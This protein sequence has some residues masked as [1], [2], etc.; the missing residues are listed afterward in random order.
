MRIIVDYREKK[1]CE[2]LKAAVSNV[3]SALLP[4]G[5][6][7]LLNDDYAVVLERKTASDLVSSI[8][9]NRL[10]E[11]L[12]N[13]LKVTDILGHSIKRRLLLV[14]GT[15]GDNFYTDSKR[16]WS[17]LS[18][19]MLEVLFVY[20]TPIVFVETDEALVQFMRIL[21]RRENEGL[22]DGFPKSRW[23][24]KTA[25]DRLPVKEKKLL[26]LD[27]IPSIGEVLSKNLLG[28]FDSIA[29]IANASVKELQ[30]VEG[31]GK[32][33]AKRIYQIFH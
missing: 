5:D 4:I 8:R 15:I 25:S 11:Q 7:V 30:K 28:Q 10:W 24:Q 21:I 1:I 22:N 27:A 31:I 12:L 14:H 23:Y 26:V 33:K 29:E 19:A 16:F 13:L 9:S 20:D 17:S 2:L 3:E 6:L 32:E 18:G